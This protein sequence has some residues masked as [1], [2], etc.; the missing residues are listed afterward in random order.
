MYL[1]LLAG[2]AGGCFAFE[3]ICFRFILGFGFVI[4]FCRAICEFGL[5][6]VRLLCKVF[7][8]MVNFVLLGLLR[9]LD[10]FIVVFFV[11]VID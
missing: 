2:H 4:L 8:F 9:V 7:G 5:H 1:G 6:V 10:Q 11:F 3:L